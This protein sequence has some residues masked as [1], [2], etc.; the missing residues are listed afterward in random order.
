M[1]VAVG[2]QLTQTQLFSER[3]DNTDNVWG[4]LA[5]YEQGIEI[6]RDAPLLGVGVN[7]YHAY[8]EELRPEEVRGVESVTFPHNTFVG[9]LAEQGLFSFIPFLIV[10]VAV[11]RVLRALSRRA[12][13]TGAAALAGAGTGAALGLLVMSLTLEMLPYGPSNSFFVI[14]MGL[15]AAQLNLIAR[16]D[17][18]GI[19]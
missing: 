1:V 2:S 15:V 8:A 12:S 9:L 18:M 13:D 14:L 10:C 19:P 6:F 7:Q 17:P 5:T 3:V 11:V 4:R 16:Q